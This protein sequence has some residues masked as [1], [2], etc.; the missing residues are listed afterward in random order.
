M[1]RKFPRK[2]N[3]FSGCSCMEMGLEWMWLLSVQYPEDTGKHRIWAGKTKKELKVRGM[4][5]W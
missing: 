2:R 5:G 1:Y 4:E 3:G